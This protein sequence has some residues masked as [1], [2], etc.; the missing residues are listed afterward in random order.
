MLLVDEI[1]SQNESS[2]VCKKTFHPDEYFFQG[3]YPGHPLTPGVILCESAVQSGAV[4]LAE[5]AAQGEGV[6][7]LTRMGDVKFK[8]MVFP[9]DTIENHV[10]LDEVVSSAFYMTAQVKCNGKLAARLSFTCTIAPPVK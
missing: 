3:H 9:G 6:P 1:V 2:I 8:N 7:V 10:T 5:I 4:L